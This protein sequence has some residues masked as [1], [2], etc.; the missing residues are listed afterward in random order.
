MCWNWAL[1]GGCGPKCQ[2]ERG[3]AVSTPDIFEVSNSGKFDPVDT[4]TECIERGAS[5]LL[6]DDGG[7]PADFFDLSTGVAGELVH[8]LTLYRIRLAG[9]IPDLSIHGVRFREFVAEANTGQAFHFF[10]T[11]EEAVRWLTP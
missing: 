1:R 7:F 3:D 4:V 8:R 6:V 5:N 9:V 10:P 2:S 11:R